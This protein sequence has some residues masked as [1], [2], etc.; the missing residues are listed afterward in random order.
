MICVLQTVRAAPIII[1]MHST[2]VN[3]VWFSFIYPW[4]P[5]AKGGARSS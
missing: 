2:L 1:F 5:G 4:F 3:Y